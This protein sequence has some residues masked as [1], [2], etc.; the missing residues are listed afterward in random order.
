MKMQL[1]LP[2]DRQMLFIG[3]TA[4]ILRRCLLFN[5]VDVLWAIKSMDSRCAINMFYV[6]NGP[7]HDVILEQ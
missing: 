2:L 5:W 7:F 4:Y 3:E 6:H 1:K